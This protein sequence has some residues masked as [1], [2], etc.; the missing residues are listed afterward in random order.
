MTYNPI[1]L[2][3]MDNKLTKPTYVD[4]KRNMDMVLTT[5]H[6]KWAAKELTPLIPNEFFMQEKKYAHL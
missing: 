5:K 6:L 2:I 3:L 1:T 4:W